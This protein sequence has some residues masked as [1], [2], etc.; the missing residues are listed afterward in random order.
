[1]AE[2][3]AY[4][5]VNGKVQ[6]SIGLEQITKRITEGDGGRGQMTKKEKEKEKNGKRKTADEERTKQRTE[7]EE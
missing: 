6:I 4:D 5:E 2:H 7:A 3:T 1:M